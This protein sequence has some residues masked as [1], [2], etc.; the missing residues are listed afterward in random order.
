M[1]EPSTAWLKKGISLA[2]RWAEVG[3]SKKTLWMN[4]FPGKRTPL[5]MEKAKKWKA[6]WQK[7][8]CEAFYQTI[9]KLN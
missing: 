2:G 9:K 8:P 4:G 5:P 6:E 1:S 3:D 7:K